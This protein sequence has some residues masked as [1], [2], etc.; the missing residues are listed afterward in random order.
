VLFG[1]PGNN[2]FCH[3]RALTF[4][5]AGVAETLEP[6]KRAPGQP[7]DY[8]HYRIVEVALSDLLEND[9]VV[10]RTAASGAFEISADAASLWSFEELRD[11]LGCEMGDD[12]PT[13]AAKA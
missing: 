10:D 3:F 8:G 4:A 9:P 2:P 6:V 12:R 5:A 7:F 13:R 1:R 11:A